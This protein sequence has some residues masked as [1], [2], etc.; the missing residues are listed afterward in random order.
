MRWLA[1]QAA[2]AAIMLISCAERQPLTT[3][4]ARA[5]GHL[6]MLPT[7]VQGSQ[8]WF[9]WDTGAPSLVIDPRLAR[10]LKLKVLK[11]DSM[12][13]T[14]AGCFPMSHSA[15]VTVTLAGVRYTVDD[16]WIIDLSGVPVSKAV[17]GLIG[18][19]LW[20]RYAVRMN[21]QKMT[22]ELF[23]PGAYRRERGEAELPLI[24]SN[25][26]MYIDVILDLKPFETRESRSGRGPTRIFASVMA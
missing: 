8:Q 10:A 4:Q 18:A 5:D 9:T 13:G 1:L 20:S 3:I 12:T 16:P 26:K 22:L 24:A 23:P 14:G 2:L 15:R 6:M 21:S 7:G 25:N 19:D 11:A 17:R